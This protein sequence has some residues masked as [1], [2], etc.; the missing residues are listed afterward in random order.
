MNRSFVFALI[1]GLFICTTAHA[2]PQG[3]CGSNCVECHTLSPDEANTIFKELG[4]VKDV[5]MS[6]VKGL[7]EIALE[8]EGRQA[9]AYLDF[10]KKHLLPG[11]VFELDTGKQITTTPI[12]TTENR[13]ID[14]SKIPLA[15]SIVMGN[16]M[17]KKK[18]FVFTDPDCPY[19][20]KMH[21]VLKKFEKIDSDTAIYVML[22]PLAMHHGAYEKSRVI[23]AGKSLE[24]L[25]K[26]FEG[27]ELPKSGKTEGKAAVDAII[28][29]A[30]DNGISDTPT[31]V[32][33][34]GSIVVGM[35]DEETLKKM[36]EG[37]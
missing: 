23:L 24:L 2:K 30:N 18:L 33:T 10:A 29:F 13:K 36:L 31:L 16:P 12:T 4:K 1:W 8:R 6:P 21:V 3:N 19:C 25:D 20:R 28:K 37:K 32:L 34:D 27:K 7:W 26:A 17:G 35:R 9:V 14:V 5:R 15:F 11:P 22:N